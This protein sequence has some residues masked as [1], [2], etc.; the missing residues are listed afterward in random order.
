MPGNNDKDALSS[1]ID[2]NISADFLDLNPKSSEEEKLYSEM[3]EKYMIHKCSS[4]TPNSCL[5][6]DGIF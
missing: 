1:W 6:S 5:N 3:V 4:G 2:D